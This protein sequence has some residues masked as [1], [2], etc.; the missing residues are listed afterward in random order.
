M[1]SGAGVEEKSRRARD[2]GAATS[3]F[4]FLKKNSVGNGHGTGITLLSLK[5]LCGGG[6]PFSHPSLGLCVFF[7]SYSQL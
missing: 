4:L 3:V 2:S 7:L 6:V 5:S 1:A